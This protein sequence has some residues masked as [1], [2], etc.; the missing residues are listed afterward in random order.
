LVQSDKNFSRTYAIGD[1]GDFVYRSEVY[2]TGLDDRNYFDLRGMHFD[3]QEQTLDTLSSG[4][5]NF[6]ARDKEQPWVLPSFDYSYTPDESVFG[7]E[8]NLD[9]NARVI[10]RDKLDVKLSE[11]NPAVFDAV[12][13]IE[14]TSS[15]LTAEAEWK[16]S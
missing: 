5:E 15:R 6:D 10:S 8:L 4:A 2:L 16:R 1:Y 9:L 3:V 7:G 12:N 11:T 13:G 14:N